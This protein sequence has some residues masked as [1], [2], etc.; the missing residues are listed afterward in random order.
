LKRCMASIGRSDGVLVCAP[1]AKCSP[2]Q[3]L[4]F[5]MR[6]RRVMRWHDLDAMPAHRVAI[7]Q[8]WRVKK[9]RAIKPTHVSLLDAVRRLVPLL[10]PV[11]YLE[12]F[13]EL[14]RAALKMPVGTPRAFYTA[15]ALYHNVLFKLLAAEHQEA[16][17]LLGHQHGGSYG[18][19]LRHAPEEY[20]RAVC[21]FFYTWGWHGGA[22]TRALSPPAF[23]RRD[24]TTQWNLM[25]CLADFP[26]TRYRV[27]YFPIAEEAQR[28]VRD[29]VDFARG[30]ADTGTQRVFIRLPP[31]DFG[32]KWFGELHAA[33]PDAH[34]DRFEKK[35]IERFAESR[36]VFHNCMSTAW[37]ESVWLDVPTLALCDPD[38]CAFRGAAEPFA[39]KFAKDGVLQPSGV[40]AARF[41]ASIRTDVE[42]WWSEPGFRAAR[43]EFIAQY[44]KVSPDWQ[45][46]WLREFTWLL[47]NRPQILARR[48]SLR[49]APGVSQPLGTAVSLS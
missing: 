25:L 24:R 30:V 27:Q 21:D 31:N 42:A 39:T 29:T 3:W 19:D 37:L 45:S 40:A 41:Y 17:L 48:N 5:V 38:I 36:L 44:V 2:L 4:G 43:A 12:G 35:A 7:D 49:R 8:I 46:E 1:Y 15:N 18:M 6:A 32:G 11:A 10:L 20:E 16:S 23:L 9:F 22:E 33:L 13:G 28:T 47:E 34:R 26:Q 14:R